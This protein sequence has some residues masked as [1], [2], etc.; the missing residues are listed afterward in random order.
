[1]KSDLLFQDLYNHSNI[2]VIK[3]TVPAIKSEFEKHFYLFKDKLFFEVM[4]NCGGIVIDNWI[5]LYGCGELNVVKKNLLFNRSG[6]EI[7]I[8]EDVLGGM[9][10]IKDGLIYYFAPDI[11]EWECLNVYY[12]NFINWLINAPERVNSFY[13]PFR[14]NNWKED[15]SK[16]ELDQGFSFYP[17][18][19]SNYNIEERSK[20][21]IK[22]DEILKFNLELKNNL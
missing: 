5:R 7:I 13:A 11:L 1:M 2:Q 10:A 3:K 21:V 17:L 15:C 22:I 19:T 6:L 4:E 8:G 16:I 9:F 18:L 12:A 14:W 20:K